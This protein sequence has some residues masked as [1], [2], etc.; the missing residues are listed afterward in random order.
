[1][2][3]VIIQLTVVFCDLTSESL[4]EREL[5]LAGEGT[6]IPCFWSECVSVKEL[7]LHMKTTVETIDLL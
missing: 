1:M 4:L 7:G 6:F 2:I 3:L 5:F